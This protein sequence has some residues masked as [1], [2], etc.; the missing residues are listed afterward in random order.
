MRGLGACNLDWCLQLDVVA[1]AAHTRGVAIIIFSS[2]MARE[3]VRV[4]G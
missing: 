4:R 2:M 3:R 1:A